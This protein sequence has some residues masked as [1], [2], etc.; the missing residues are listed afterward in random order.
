MVVAEGTFY[1]WRKYAGLKSDQVL[2][3]KK[4][5]EENEKLKRIVSDLTLDKINAT[6]SKY[7]KVVGVS[8]RHKATR[9]LMGLYQTSE[10]RACLL[11]GLSRTVCR[12]K[13]RRELK[14][15]LRQRVVE[16]A[17]FEYAIITNVSM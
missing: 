17:Q 8:Q 16:I 13:P 9:H 5:R 1:A 15:A 7:A 3:F 12:Y 14:E 11:K 10:R 6:G 4:L 2:E